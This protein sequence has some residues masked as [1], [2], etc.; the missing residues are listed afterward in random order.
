[1][2][3]VCIVL[4]GSKVAQPVYQALRWDASPGADPPWYYAIR[5]TEGAPGI[6]R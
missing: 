5:A 1:M 4:H 3:I 6:G 2:T